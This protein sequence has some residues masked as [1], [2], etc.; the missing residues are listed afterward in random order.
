MAKPIFIV[1]VG[2]LPR[3]ENDKIEVN[4]CFDYLREDYHVLIVFDDTKEPVKF[5]MFSDKKL[6]PIDLKT[7]QDK[8]N[9]G[10]T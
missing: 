7:L 6:E 2:F 1:Q 4:K 8:I 9:N 5:Q 3:D 10:T